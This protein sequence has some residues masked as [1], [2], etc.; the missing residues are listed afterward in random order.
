MPLV[1]VAALTTGYAQKAQ[2]LKVINT[3]PLVL[4]TTEEVQSAVLGE[5]RVLNIYLPE[6]YKKEDTTKYPVVYLLDGGAEEDFVH[7]VGLIRYNTQ[8]WINRFPRS[9]VV[10]IENTNRRKDFTFAVPNLDFVTRIGYKPEHFPAYGGSARFISFLKEE[11]QPYINSHYNTSGQR[12]IIGESLAGLMATEILLKHRELFDNYIIMSPSLWWG[13]ES[14]LAEAPALL[15]K[16]LDKDIKVYI[17]ACSKDEDKI[18]YDDAVALD[19]TLKKYGGSRMK[20]YYDY[21]P[22]E[23]H[24]TII[25]QAVYSAFRLL[26]PHTETQ[27]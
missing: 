6:G 24:A 14:L 22:G 13:K 26:Y 5:K 7:V 10:G 23:I 27:Y 16:S 3:K 11:L 18:M 17:G 4:A 12:T 1:L 19:E 8:P 20:V 2:P 15:K 9:I 25:H 21:L